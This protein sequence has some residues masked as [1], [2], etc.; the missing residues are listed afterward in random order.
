LA[1]IPLLGTLARDLLGS[2]F[3]DDAFS[4]LCL[5]NAKGKLRKLM[6]GSCSARHP[7]SHTRH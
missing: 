2:D 3:V 7:T 1:E 4:V 5:H 6:I